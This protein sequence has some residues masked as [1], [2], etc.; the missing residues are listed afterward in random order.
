MICMNV[1]GVL[2]FAVGLL[3]CDVFGKLKNSARNCSCFCSLIGNTRKILSSVFQTPGFRRMFRPV[4]SLG[5]MQN[6]APMRQTLTSM[7]FFASA[8]EG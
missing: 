6:L 5:K 2:T 7:L 4:L 3:K 8:Q 1:L